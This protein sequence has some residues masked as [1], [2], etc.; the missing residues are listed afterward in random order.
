MIFFKNVELNNVNHW[1]FLNYFNIILT[2]L[3]FTDFLWV[4]LENEQ[5]KKAS[6]SEEIENLKIL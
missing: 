4:V 1:F 5:F 6:C 3:V 2:L